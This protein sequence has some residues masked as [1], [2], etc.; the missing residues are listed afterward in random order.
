MIWIGG[1]AYR[2]VHEHKDGWKPDIFKERYSEVLDRY[3][4]IVGDW[5]YNQLRLK[6]FFREGGGRSAKDSAIAS[7]QEYLQE[8]C[9][10]GCAYFVLERVHGKPLDPDGTSLDEGLN[11]AE[12]ESAAAKAIDAAE[13]VGGSAAGRIGEVQFSDRKPYSWREDQAPARNRNPERSGSG[14]G[15]A[16]E[17]TASGGG[18]TAEGGAPE[19]QAGA[20]GRG[21][22]S[23][24][25]SGGYRPEKRPPRQ[26]AGERQASV[27]HQ[28]ADDRSYAAR[29]DQS[30]ERQSHR[31]SGN[32]GERKSQ[33]GHRNGGGGPNK[34]RGGVRHTNAGRNEGR[35]RSQQQRHH[36]KSQQQSQQRER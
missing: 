8:Y 22:R 26:E 5:G 9:N 15:D 23:S 36:H 25:G 29:G 2:L 32:P 28:G 10:F 16:A 14:G 30:G 24:S 19:S 33:K 35:D 31:P 3:D 4:Y 12:G 27:P 1:K 17:K 18:K 34:G 20:K 21:P 7:L 13:E 11:S 6:G